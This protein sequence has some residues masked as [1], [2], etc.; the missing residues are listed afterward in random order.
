MLG[1]GC[2]VCAACVAS[3][4]FC[5]GFCGRVD[6]FCPR[7]ERC[8]QDV[9]RGHGFLAVALHALLNQF[10]VGC[11][12]VGARCHV[13]AR[14]VHAHCLLVDIACHCVVGYHALRIEQKDSPRVGVVGAGRYRIEEI[15]G[16]GLRVIVF[17]EAV[18]ERRAELVS[19]KILLAVVEHTLQECHLVHGIAG[20]VEP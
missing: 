5:V 19:Q 3:G 11:G 10:G 2:T 1:G 8:Q 20:E 7:F 9:K 6:L 17:A 4:S 15:V 12:I 14:T 18:V 13:H 16:R